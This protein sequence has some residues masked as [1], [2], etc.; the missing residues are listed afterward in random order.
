MP[1]RL[2]TIE[3]VAEYFQVSKGAIYKRIQRGQI[4]YMKM[5]SLLRF[6]PSKIEEYIRENTIEPFKKG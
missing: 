5:G 1:E 6:N 4:P 3:E 2:M